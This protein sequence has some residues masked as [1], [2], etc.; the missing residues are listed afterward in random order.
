MKSTRSIGIELQG[1][2]A[3]LTLAQGARG[4][5]FDLS[6]VT[7]FKQLVDALWE[8]SGL[9]AV[10]LRAEGPNFSVGGNIKEFYPIRHQLPSMVRRGTGD[11]HMALQ[12]LWKLPVPVIAAVHGYTMGAGAALMAGCDVV[13]AAE[14]AQIGSAFAGIGF[15]CDSGS[16]VTFTFRMGAARARRFL[17]LAET[18][19]AGEAMQAGLVDRVI[20]DQELHEQSLE[21][22]STMAAGP[23]KAY[24]E[25]KRL[26]LRAG[27]PHME[28]QFEEEALGLTQVAGSAD[29]Q[30]GVAAIFE[31]RKPI[32]RGV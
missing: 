15:S 29:A 5:P 13:L 14:S 16:S 26:F 19:K 17:L 24:G 9:R 11:L 10:L 23:T 3:V 28:V 1:G 20:P 18:L 32:F 22:A 7:D 31:K 25:I 27:A 12:R 4:N 30:E 2:L 21:L 6:F 8:V